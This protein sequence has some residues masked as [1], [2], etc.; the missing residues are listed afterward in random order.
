MTTDHDKPKFERK[1]N[2]DL[3]RVEAWLYKTL[4]DA[5]DEIR[6]SVHFI[7]REQM[8]GLADIFERWNDRLKAANHREPLSSEDSTD[9]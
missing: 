5:P 4:N 1:R 6:N 2:P 8:R 9:G 3:V 7:T